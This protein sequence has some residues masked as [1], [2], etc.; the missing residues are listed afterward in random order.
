[1]S[2]STTKIKTKT[3]AP[4]HAVDGGVYRDYARKF[5]VTQTAT[6]PRGLPA[7]ETPASLRASCRL[8]FCQIEASKN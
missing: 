1:M 4:A 6:T 3:I 2:L 7:R 5:V 8:A